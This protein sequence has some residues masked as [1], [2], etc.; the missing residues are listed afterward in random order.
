MALGVLLVGV[1]GVLLLGVLRV[2]LLGVLGVLLPLHKI[3]PILPPPP[4][5]SEHK[6]TKLIRPERLV[7]AVHAEF[8]LRRYTII[9]ARLAQLGR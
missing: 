2:L 9:G 4:V 3:G 8:I 1:L 7:F 5:S 6:S